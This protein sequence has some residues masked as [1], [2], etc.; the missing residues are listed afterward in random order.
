MQGNTSVTKSKNGELNYS[1]STD[2]RPDRLDFNSVTTPKGGEYRVVLPDGSHV[3]LNAASSLKFP[4]SF[5][6][7]ERRVELTGEAYFE[8]AHNK[9]LPF[10]VVTSSQVVQVLGTHFN[11]MAYADEGPAKT[12]LLEGSVKVG[13]GGTTKIIVPGQQAVADKT[14]SVRAVDAEAVVAWKNGQTYFKNTDIPT[15]MRTLSR[16]YDVEVE[17]QGKIPERR[18]TGGIPR[19][20]NLSTMLRILGEMDIH[21]RIQGHKIVIKP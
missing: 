8:V 18:F 14:L 17:Y 9:A 16:W 10:R 11:V 21:T 4:V 13:V 1:I 7:R 12:T 20:S 3:W 19:K 2:E 5:R 6:G 15:M